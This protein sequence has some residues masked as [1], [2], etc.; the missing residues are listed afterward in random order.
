MLRLTERKVL[1]SMCPGSSA[2]ADL[3]PSHSVRPELGV[4]G[5][6]GI[7][8]CYGVPS[9]VAESMFLSHCPSHH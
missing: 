5:R 2:W 6:A 7:W 1:R 3:L 4:C 9:G 8:A